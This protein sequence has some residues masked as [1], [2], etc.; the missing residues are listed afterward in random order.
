MH[1]VIV[2]SGIPGLLLDDLAISGF[3][4]CFSFYV[5]GNVLAH[6]SS[7]KHIISI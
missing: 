6:S 2:V 3:I 4:P 1:N 5:L 7:G